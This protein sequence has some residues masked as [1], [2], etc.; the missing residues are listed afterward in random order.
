[1]NGNLGNR[2]DLLNMKDRERVVEDEIEE[3]Q[4]AEISATSDRKPSKLATMIRNMIKFT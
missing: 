2:I 4:H 1:M 3:S